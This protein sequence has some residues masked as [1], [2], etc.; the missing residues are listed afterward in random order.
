MVNWFDLRLGQSENY[1]GF[2]NGYMQ[3]VFTFE[4]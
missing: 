4:S 2:E 3:L 1:S